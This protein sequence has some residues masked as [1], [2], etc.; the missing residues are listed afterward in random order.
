MSLF[1]DMAKNDGGRQPKVNFNIVEPYQQ[2]QF[3]TGRPKSPGDWGGVI[4]V[5]N[6]KTIT[7]LY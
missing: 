1:A 4:F 3:Y 2:G 7:F 6:E 5:K